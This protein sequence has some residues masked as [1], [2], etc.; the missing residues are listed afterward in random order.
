MQL[1][2]IADGSREDHLRARLH[3]YVRWAT[4]VHDYPP[5]DMEPGDGAEARTDD[6]PREMIAIPIDEPS[7]ADAPPPFF[8]SITFA[9]TGTAALSAPRP[10]D[11]GTGAGWL[12]H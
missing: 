9:P 7:D 8:G 11:E 5:E 3:A 10:A 6:Q 12:V 4:A 2:E 1:L